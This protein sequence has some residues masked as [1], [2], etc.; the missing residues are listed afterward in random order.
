MLP[1]EKEDRKIL[2]SYQETGSRRPAEACDVVEESIRLVR[3]FGRTEEGGPQ[4]ERQSSYTTGKAQPPPEPMYVTTPS[5]NFF[6]PNGL[7]TNSDVDSRFDPLTGLSNKSHS[8]IE[9]HRAFVVDRMICEG[10]MNN[11][12]IESNGT[13]DP[14][15]TTEAVSPSTCEKQPVLTWTRK[16]KRPRSDRSRGI[17]ESAAAEFASSD[18]QNEDRNIDA[19]PLIIPV[20]QNALQW[21]KQRLNEHDD[22]ATMAAI[23]ALQDEVSSEDPTT[24]N[25]L[26][27]KIEGRDNTFASISDLQQYKRDLES[28]PAALEESA[29]AYHRVPIDQ[30]GA[31]LLRGMGWNEEDEGTSNHGKIRDVLPRPHR[32]GLG[33]IPA[34][35]EA[36]PDQHLPS[37]T[38]ERHRPKSVHQYQRD[39]RLKGQQASYRVEREQL[40]AADRQRT[41]QDGSIVR[42]LHKDTRARILKLVGVPGLNMVQIQRE[43]DA[44]PS[45]IK[46]SEMDGL[47][48]R[49]ELEQSP[50]RDV[51]QKDPSESRTESSSRKSRSTNV[52]RTSHRED[53]WN[54][55][56]KSKSSHS[57]DER[58]STGEKRRSSDRKKVESFTWVIPNIRVRI[59]TEKL[60]RRYYKEKG[61]VTDVTRESGITVH[62]MNGEIV[63][64]IPERYLETALPK[65]GGN[66]IVLT[67]GTGM[68]KNA[69][70]RL[71]ERDSRT[72]LVQLYENMDCI[73]VSLDDIAEW[74]GP[75][76]DDEME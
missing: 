73:S 46:R 39:Q 21:Q 32:L 35:P 28:L 8:H 11:P 17:L 67:D 6:P 44:V 62:L 43:G 5:A 2:S 48:S 70:G 34:L 68:H 22:V 59:V 53:D 52:N 31:A 15:G 26:S 71:L 38:G 27:V 7:F 56:R 54:M 47:V 66:V 4:R 13:G 69:R 61:M 45:V 36:L 40:R 33:A 12:H 3:D 19:G 55:E 14:N 50:F 16:T 75:L 18:T 25:A 23:Q 24:A 10:G 60:G 41:L 74:C 64:E 72:G 76:D 1:D 29:E 42:L 57:R 65:P 20:P 30:F 63:Q 9:M 49:E 58:Q 37:A 51:L